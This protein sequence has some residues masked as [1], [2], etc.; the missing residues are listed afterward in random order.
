[1]ELVPLDSKSVQILSSPPLSPDSL[2]FVVGESHKESHTTP[3]TE[4]PEKRSFVDKVSLDSFPT[5]TIEPTHSSSPRKSRRPRRKAKCRRSVGV[6]GSSASSDS[7]NS[8]GLDNF[9]A[10]KSPKLFPTVLPP[11]VCDKKAPKRLLDLF[12]GTGSVGAVY[13]AQGFEVTSLDNVPKWKADIREDILEWDYTVFPP[14]YFHTVV[15]GVPCT[16]FS[17]AKTVG[18]RDLGLA[19]SIV[20][21]TLEILEYLKPKKW[22]ME[23]P[24]HGLLKTREYM[25]GIPYTDADYCQYSDWGYKKP[26]RFWGSPGIEKLKLRLCDRLTCPNVTGILRA[27]G[28]RKHR[29]TLS[30]PH[31][32]LPTHLKYRIPAALILELGGFVTPLPRGDEN[33]RVRTTKCLCEGTSCIQEGDEIVAP[34]PIIIPERLLKAPQEYGIWEIKNEEGKRQLLLTLSATLPDHSRTKIM[35]LID[36]GAEAN[37]IKKGLFLKNS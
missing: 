7:T 31:Q 5:Q 17:I 29:I 32:N 10:S 3:V 13:R 21:K 15:C 28:Q 16:E 11:G 14:G 26:T 22:W 27:N 35:A 9:P 23:N 34:H 12:C 18:T 37:L 8:G 2:A 24:R 6:R 20:I 4:T 1:M 36:T 30:S 19:D 33:K 25:Q